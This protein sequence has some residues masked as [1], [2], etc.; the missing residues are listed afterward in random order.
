M[1][2]RCRS[3]TNCPHAR[4]R[5]RTKPI[6][7]LHIWTL[8]L[9]CLCFAAPS[10]NAD[11]PR[12][13]LQQGTAI[14]VSHQGVYKFKADEPAPLWSSLLGIETFA[15]VRDGDLLLVGSTQ[16]LFAL[17]MATGKVAWHIEKR[18]TIFTPSVSGQAYAGSL[19]GEL[20]AVEPSSGAISWRQ[21]FPGWI[22][23]PVFD[24][25]S[26]L[27]WSAGQAHRLVAVSI[28]EGK[29]LQQ[30]ETVQE[31]VFSPVDLG[32][33]SIGINLFDGSTVVVDA[34]SMEIRGMLSGDSQPTSL[35]P[36]NSHIYRSH[37][38]GT[39]SA[40]DRDRL[41]LSW[42][43]SFVTQDL[44]MHPSQADYLLLSDNDRKLILLDLDRGSIACQL[45]PDGPWALPIQIETGQVVYFR[46]SM[47]PPHMT[48]VK[49]RANCKAN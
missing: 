26:G 28:S 17:E 36:H 11:Y 29:I 42:R 15:P 45:E 1:S 46:K 24:L 6:N 10:A 44:A 35:S 49:P 37:R 38:D 47:Q 27:L 16:G 7:R 33:R 8:I 25:E 14:Y 19:H 41:E 40:F 4:S 31:A 13:P 39:L 30:I 18:R 21:S 48:L 23:S 12:N 20:Y 22:Y 5:I 43:R 3:T 2:R 34:A 32:N 9:C